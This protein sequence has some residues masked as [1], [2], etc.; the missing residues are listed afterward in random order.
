MTKSTTSERTVDIL[1][2]IFAR[3]GLPQQLVSDNGPQFVSEEFRE[4]LRFNESAPYHPATN[5]LAERFVH[6]F[7]H[8]AP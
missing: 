7:K 2:T 4:F 6:T 1:S 5:G 3:N 8:F